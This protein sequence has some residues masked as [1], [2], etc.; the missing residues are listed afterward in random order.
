MS[1]DCPIFEKIPVR[2]GEL[3]TLRVDDYHCFRGLTV[4][5]HYHMM[6]EIMWFR[7]STGTFSIGNEKYT[8]KNNTLIFVPALMVHDMDLAA[9]EDHLRYLLQF[10]E[11]YLDEYGIDI[12]SSQLIREMV[13]VLTELEA[14]RLQQIFSWCSDQLKNSG[15]F[16]PLFKSL[17]KT[18]L[19][20]VFNKLGQSPYAKV[21][22]VDQHINTLMD[23]VHDLDKNK[24]YSISTE[25]AAQRCHWSK[26]WF[27]RIFKST[28][29]MP[30][31][32]F[33][34]VRKINVAVKLL[35][36]TDVAIATVAEQAGFCDSAYFCLR[37]KE[38]MRETP[39]IFRERVKNS[40]DIAFSDESLP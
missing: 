31:K 38:M 33:M 30:F 26:S 15:S 34:V 23:F 20:D 8:I 28:F 25:E 7:R 27:S 35:A 5:P 1:D 37:F 17:L 2:V 40:T 18:I 10:E 13:R 11:N 16:D 9:G 32:T 39:K 3:F 36:T 14:T 6:F 4:E 29:G 21:R 22:P 24:E 12:H 19:L